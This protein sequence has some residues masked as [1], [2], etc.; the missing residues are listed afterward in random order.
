MIWCKKQGTKQTA[1]SPA[2]NFLKAHHLLYDILVNLIEEIGAVVA[3]DIERKLLREIK[4]EDT[5]D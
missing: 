4:T 3:V 5:H 1:L 2:K